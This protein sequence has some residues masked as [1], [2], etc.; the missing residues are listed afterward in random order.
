[1]KNNKKVQE[2]LDIKGIVILFSVLIGIVILIYLLTLGAQKIGLF[3]EGYTKPEVKTPII[4]YEKILAGNVFNMKDETYYVMIADFE[5]LDSVY[6]SSLGSLYK[7]KKDSLPLYTVDLSEGMNK[8]IIGENINR[9]AQSASELSVGA[10][11]LIKIQNGRN[12]K[13]IDNVEDVKTE[14]GI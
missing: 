9:E 3:D 5:D 10:Q 8:K 14:L 1:M 11:T 7:D 12:V 4:S 2:E 13:Y 6:F